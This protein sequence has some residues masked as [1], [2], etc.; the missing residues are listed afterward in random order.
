MSPRAW[1]RAS[2]VLAPKRRRCAFSFEKAISIGLR[3]GEQAGRKSLQQ[4]WAFNIS[5]ACGLLWVDRLS[6]ITTVPGASAGAR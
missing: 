3:S 5:A 4:P 1:M 6:R 2:Q